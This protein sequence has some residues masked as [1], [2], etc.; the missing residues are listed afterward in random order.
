MKQRS[1]TRAPKDLIAQIEGADA[2]DDLFDAKVTVLGEYIKHH[3]KKNRR[4]VPASAQNEAR[5]ARAR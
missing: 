1:S 5:S 4:D 3:V 2:G